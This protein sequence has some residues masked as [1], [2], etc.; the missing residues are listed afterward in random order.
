MIWAMGVLPIALLI[1][2]F[3]IFVILLISSAAV[4]LFYTHVPLTQMHLEM[5]GNIDQFALISVP[6]F[7]FAGELMGRGGMARRL[8]DWV[9]SMIGGVQG[10]L[11]LTVVGAN[12]VFGSIS[13]SSAAAVAAIGQILYPRM[14]ESGYNERFSSGLLAS[15]GSIGLIIPPSIIMI[16]YGYSAEQSIALL[17]V[18]G[19]LPGILIAGMLAVYLIVY[20]KR[21]GIRERAAFSWSDFVKASKAGSWAIGM[22]AIIL[23]GI[24]AGIFSPTEAAG[25]ACVYA[26][27]VTRYIYGDVGWKDIWDVAVSSMYLTAQV[28]IIVA[29]SGVFAWLLTVSG[30]PQALTQTISDLHAAPW[31]VLL[32]INVLLLAVGCL[33]DPG[34]AILVLTPLLAP[35]ARHIGVDLVHFG[36]IMTVNLA[37]GMFTPPFGI[38]IFV[39]QA[40][41]KT[42]LSSLY[43]G[44]VPFIIIN[45]VALFVITYIPGLSLFLTHY[46]H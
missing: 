3:P 40:V 21:R 43:P 4:L 13:G 24:Y 30:V 1:L 9:L 11:P 20:A 26:I 17:F 41:F 16:L 46:I 8:V 22:P 45:I 5:F 15:A 12:T 44:L 29:A 23:G 32:A 10:S 35:V 42:P 14:L 27:L 28:L 19:I 33:L 25:V 37:I 2:G 6:F 34:S 7:I 36:I 38:N 31:E 39:A 18:A